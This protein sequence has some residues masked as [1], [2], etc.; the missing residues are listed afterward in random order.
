MQ[1]WI[2]ECMN[3]FGYWGVLLLIALENLFPPIPSEVILTFGGFMTTYTQM[4]PWL[5]ILF[6]TGGSLIGAVVLYCLGR[7]LSPERLDRWFCKWGKVLHFKQGDIQKADLWFKRKGGSAVLLCRFVP[8][9]R[10]LISLPAGMARMPWGK[11]LSLTTLGTLGWNIVL[12]WLG[13]IAGSQ[14]KQISGFFDTYS[15][16]VLVVL[17]VVCIVGVLVLYKRKRANASEEKPHL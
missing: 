6:A 4:N 16:V 2:I 8:I 17:A 12:V 1:E 7:F 9:V 3:A 5:V 11:F 14:W 15:T 13:A 10:S